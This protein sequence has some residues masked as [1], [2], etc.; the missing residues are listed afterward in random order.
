[1]PVPEAVEFFIDGAPAIGIA[2]IAIS[3]MARNEIQKGPYEDMKPKDW[4]PST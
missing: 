3:K 2:R 4:L 1:M